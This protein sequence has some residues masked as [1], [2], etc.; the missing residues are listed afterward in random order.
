MR[1][2]H[3]CSRHV[4]SFSGNLDG[5]VGGLGQSRKHFDEIQPDHKK[6]LNNEQFL[7]SSGNEF[8][9]KINQQVVLGP[10]LV[11]PSMGFLH[12]QCNNIQKA[13]ADSLFLL[14]RIYPKVRRNDT[15]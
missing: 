6:L 1:C 4:N 8:G 15:T 9:F 3:Q 14:S 10:V 2:L 12:W 5:S 11:L 13:S 7:V